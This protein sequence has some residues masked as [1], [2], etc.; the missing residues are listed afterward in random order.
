M[1]AEGRKL[2]T[3][4]GFVQL[5]QCI[6]QMSDKHASEFFEHGQAEASNTIDLGKIFP[7]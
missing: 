1:Y 5:M 6:F 4:E 2:M 3:V 7:I